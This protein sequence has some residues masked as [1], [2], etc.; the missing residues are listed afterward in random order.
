M[1]TKSARSQFSTLHQIASL[2]PG[3]LVSKLAR[4]HGVDS[5]WRT[6]SPWSHVVALV[7]AQLAHSVS[8]NDVFTDEAGDAVSAASFVADKEARTPLDDA[9]KNEAIDRL[10]AAIGRLPEAHQKV[11]HLYYNEELTLKEIGA[12]MEVSE[13]R[14]CQIHKEATRKLRTIMS[15]S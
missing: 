1:S 13:S 10:S 15:G 6:F 11:L 3:H 12:V 7:Y 4:K 9:M 5:Q 14:I 2:I 8:L